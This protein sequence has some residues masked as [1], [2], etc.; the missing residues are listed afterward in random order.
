M[1]LILLIMSGVGFGQTLSLDECVK[2]ALRNNPDVQKSEFTLRQSQISTQQAWSA[3]YP[4]ISASASTSN[5][6]P[7][8]SDMQDEWNWNIGGGVSQQFYR[9]GMYSGISLA[10]ERQTLSAYSNLSL[11]D[12]I[13]TSVERL[14]FEILVSDTTIGVYRANIKLSDEQITKMERMVELGLKRQSDL[15]KSKVQRGTFEAQLIREMESQASTKRSLNIMMGRDPNS[16]LSIEPFDVEEISVPDYATAYEMM[17]E[18]NPTIKYRK[19]QI[20]VQ[21]LSHRISKEAFLPSVS[22][23]YSYSQSND[24]YSGSTHDNDQVSLRLSLDIF[25]GFTKRQNMQSAQL[26]LDEARLDYEA[27]LRDLDQAL[28]NQYRAL[29]TQ[30]QLILIHQT[31]LASARQDL[32]VVSQQYDAG[33]SS[34]LDLMDAQLSVL[35][36]ETNLLQDLYTRKQIEAEIRRL[37]GEQQ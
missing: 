25:D 9:P 7:F 23:S 12:Q 33:F 29:E 13:R 2:L 14:Y 17:L 16:D 36:S 3:L 4:G 11:K 28:S 20:R 35:Q 26:N 15:L 19:S 30:N 18:Y 21:Q 31:N 27:S 24:I 37:I 8:V 1:I 32:E 6:G 22:G 10:R 5:S 34:I